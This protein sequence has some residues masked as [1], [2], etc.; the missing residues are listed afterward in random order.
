M[1]QAVLGHAGEAIDSRKTFQAAAKSDQDALIE[2]LKSLQVPP[3]GT[4]ALVVDEKFQPKRWGTVVAT[5][6]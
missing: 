2:F 1:R 5:A 3:P 6:K 4:P